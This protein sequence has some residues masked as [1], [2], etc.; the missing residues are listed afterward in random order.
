[1]EFFPAVGTANGHCL[2]TQYHTVI[3]NCE[4]VNA[5]IHS[6]CCDAGSANRMLFRLIQKRKIDTEGKSLLDE[7]EC[8]AIHPFDATRKIFS[9]SLLC[10]PFEI[11]SKLSFQQ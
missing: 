8:F 10:S 3:Q 2:L 11:N 6:V 1:L 5:K 4:L 9:L 7:D